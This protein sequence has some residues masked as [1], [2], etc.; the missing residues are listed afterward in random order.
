MGRSADEEGLAGDAV[1]AFHPKL[2]SLFTRA[3]D[4]GFLG[5]GPVAVQVERARDLGAVVVP[6]SRA[7]D[8]GSGGGLPGLVL[9][10]KWPDSEWV[11]L[12]ANHRR[13]AFLTE[14]VSQLGWESR[15]TVLTERA[16]VTG[17][18]D[19]RGWADLVVARGFGPPAVTAECGAPLL[20]VG[21]SLVVTEPP[22]GEA[23]RWP[24]DELRRLGL[25]PVR[26][27]TA[28][29]SA[30]ILRLVQPCPPR[31]PRR[32]GIPAKRPLF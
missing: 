14:A 18:S 23:S 30:Q 15:V 8:L 9:A 32:V 17:R 4:Y 20:A 25:E 21:G 6:P 1:A 7:I 19:R 13:T 26:L 29:T 2:L 5:P 11:L 16:E 3:Q 12:D 27:V 31:F 10:A 28:P 24:S 22:G